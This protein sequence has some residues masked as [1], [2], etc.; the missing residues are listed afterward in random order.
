VTSLKW[1]QL[2]LAEKGNLIFGNSELIEKLDYPMV[3]CSSGPIAW[4]DL[5]GPVLCKH[6]SCTKTL[7]N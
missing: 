3:A 6:N 7:F 2:Q 5:S 4:S 1:P